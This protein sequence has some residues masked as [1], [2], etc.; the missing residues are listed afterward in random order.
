MNI[1]L[2]FGIVIWLIIAVLYCVTIRKAYINNDKRSMLICAIMLVYAFIEQF[3]QNCFMNV[4]FLVIVEYCWS[5]GKDSVT[6]ELDT[7]YI[8]KGQGIG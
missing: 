5:R 4:S 8:E 6:G 2:Q 1:L 3:F 7:G